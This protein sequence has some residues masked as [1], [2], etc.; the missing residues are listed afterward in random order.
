MRRLA[1]ALMAAA[2]LDAAACGGCVDDKIASC[3][4][5]AVVSAAQQ[6]GHAVAFFAI[7]GDVVRSAQTRRAVLRAI[8]ATPG[9]RRGSARVSLENAALSFAYDPARVSPQQAGEAIAGA[10]R[11]RLKL[12]RLLG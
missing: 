8:E 12:L 9:V 4:D 6:R 1:L 2:A 10:L 7:E 11:L 3:Y 5:H